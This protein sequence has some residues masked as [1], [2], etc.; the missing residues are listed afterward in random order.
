MQRM[1]RGVMGMLTLAGV[2]VGAP[3]A[4]GQSLYDRPV[5]APTRDA[6]GVLNLDEVTVGQSLYAVSSYAIRPPKPREFAVNDLVT[7]IISHS[8]SATREGETSYAKD[9]SMS[10]GVR[11]LPDLIKL[12]QLRYENYENL[13][14]TLD[15]D[16]GRE[17]GGEGEES[18]NTNLT[19]RVTA[20]VEAVLPNG[21]I[22]LTSR[23]HIRI[24]EEEE[25]IVISGWCNPQ[26]I[27][28]T[29][30]IQSSRMYDLRVSL[31]QTG[32][33]RQSTRKG[34]IPRVFDAIFNF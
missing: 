34:V 14:I 33:V 32:Q 27:S 22:L 8:S 7:V 12:L 29:N 16:F 25:V 21:T 30:T 23:T 17:F 20:R 2:L 19:S 18:T 13:P 1:K 6:N 10:G 4:E 9:W 5:S 28:A 24:N 3:A 11:S 15:A 31:E 26:D